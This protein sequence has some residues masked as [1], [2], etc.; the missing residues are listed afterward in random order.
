[1]KKHT[2][3]E[4]KIQQNICTY[5]SMIA[6]Q[7]GIVY[8]SVPNE[9]I[10]SVLK[11]FK[12]PDKSCY[13]IVAFFKKMGLLPGV[14]DIVIIWRGMAFCMEV[15]NER[16]KQSPDQVLFQSNIVKAGAKYEVVR[17]I[18]DVQRVLREWGIM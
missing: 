11:M 8:F 6:H 14:S 4:S 12:V 16:G 15:K 17:G 18:E 13:A 5:L 2:L 10:M 9:G 3:S 7:T 1:M